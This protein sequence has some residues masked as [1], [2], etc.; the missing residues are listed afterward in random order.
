MSQTVLVP[1][2]GGAAA[3]S[4]IK[5]LRLADFDGRIV[6]TDADPLSAG[7]YLSDGFRIVPKAKDPEF[8]AEVRRLIDEERVDVILPTSGFDIYEFAR[9]KHELTSAGIAVAM[10]D[11]HAISLCSNAWE[12]HLK[13]QG[14]FPLPDTSRDHSRWQRFP[15][16]VKPVFAKGSR[17][18]QRCDSRAELQFFASRARDIIV[19]EYMPGDEYTADVLSDLSGTPLLAV[20]R[21]RLDTKEGIYTRGRVVRDPE[22][23]Q[24]CLEMA[25]HLGLK[26]PTCMKLKRDAGGRPRFLDVKPRLSGG[27]IFTT[28]AGVNIPK[29]LLDVIAGMEF[30]PPTP[31][32][33]I[34]LRYYDEVILD[35]RAP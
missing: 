15:C 30:A 12:F 13:T 29:L 23:E 33:I 4:T 9:H 25:S 21:I 28:L 32:E 26:G 7:F 3:I 35:A 16:F 10:S 6:S 20:P 2:A 5:S 19:Q 8:Y 24:L 11:L 1:G 27:S 22:I 18:S 17:H 31:R 34:V 14:A